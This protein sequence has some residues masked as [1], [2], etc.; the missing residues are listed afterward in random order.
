M[1]ANTNLQGGQRGI[2]SE[3]RHPLLS[4]HPVKSLGRSTGC[5]PVEFRRERCLLSDTLAP[6][7]TNAALVRPRVV[8]ICCGAERWRTCAAARAYHKDRPRDSC[9]LC[10]G[11][12]G[13]ARPRSLQLMLA[14]R[15]CALERVLL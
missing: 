14:S 9:P 15:R 6:A 5:P 12:G 4:L 1:G 8:D 2:A 13:R 11:G 7:R 3:N 10:V